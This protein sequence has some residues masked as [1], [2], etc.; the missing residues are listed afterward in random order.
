VSSRGWTLA[1]FVLALT[2]LH[3]LARVGL[4]LGRSVP[5]LLAVAVLL[6]GRRMNG[7]PAMLMGTLLGLLE[8]ATGIH[9]LGARAIG[10]GAVGYAAARSRRN[11]TGEGFGFTPLFLFV[12][13]WVSLV[14]TWAIRR[15]VSSPPADLLLALPIDAAYAALAGAFV[16]RLLP[17]RGGGE[18]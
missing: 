1:A 4:G 2:A 13:T 17:R 11:L 9:N 5:D 6:V 8:D 16:A 7:A 18:L 3:F 10:L 14:L 12:G 15:P